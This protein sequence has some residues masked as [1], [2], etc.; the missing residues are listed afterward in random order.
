MSVEMR[1]PAAAGRIGDA[2]FDAV[3]AALA[4]FGY[5]VVFL[6]VGRSANVPEAALSSLVNLVP[7]LAVAAAAR[8]LIRRYLIGRPFGRQLAGHVALAAAF[9]MLWYWLLMVMIGVRSGSSFTE[10]AVRAFFPG[11]AVA[12]QLLQ[13][14]TLYALVAAITEMRAQPELPSFVLAPAAAAPAETKEPELS[15]YFIRRGEDIYPVDVSRIVSIAGADDYAEVATLEGRHLVRTTLAEF[16]AS[17]DPA[18][19]ARVHRSRI[20]NLDRV[21]RAEPAGGGRM[22]LHME[23]GEAIQTSRTGAKLLRGRVI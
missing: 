21:A 2:A 14:L 11:P 12:W 6:L 13:G 19:F 17:L 5:F 9:A 23:D 18:R 16:E 22:L 10:F 3:A 15:R 1:R 20:V 4:F 8:A 7:L